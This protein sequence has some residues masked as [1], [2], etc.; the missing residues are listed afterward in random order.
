MD[1]RGMPV[2]NKYAALHV[3]GYRKL[4]IHVAQKDLLVTLSSIAS[5]P[6]MSKSGS[7]KE[8]ADDYPTPDFAEFKQGEVAGNASDET[9]SIVAKWLWVRFYVGRRL[10][11]ISQGLLFCFRYS[12]IEE[13]HSLTPLAHACE[14]QK[15]PV[16]SMKGNF[17]ERSY[18]RLKS[19]KV[20]NLCY[21]YDWY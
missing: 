4:F 12:A 11:P 7:D 18:A 1:V 20:S 6:K 21:T 9:K 13:L 10:V 8:K 3:T 2:A 14:S 15:F 19:S 17:R 16:T 5:G